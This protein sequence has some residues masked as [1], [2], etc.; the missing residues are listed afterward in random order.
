M[1]IMSLLPPNEDQE[2]P[3]RKALTEALQ[4]HAKSNGYDAAGRVP[5]GAMRDDAMGSGATG[6]TRVHSKSDTKQRKCPMS[7]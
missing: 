1:A 5:S 6:N 3:D 7:N 4:A 2:Y